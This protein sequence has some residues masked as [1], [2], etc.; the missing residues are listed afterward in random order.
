MCAC[1]LPLAIG[2]DGNGLSVRGRYER[3]GYISGLTGGAFEQ[4][5]V[6]AA[7]VTKGRIRSFG[8]KNISHDVGRV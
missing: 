7:T 3:K 5:V 8:E 4:G 1:N 2:D 6:V